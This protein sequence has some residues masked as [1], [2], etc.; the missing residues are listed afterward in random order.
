MQRPTNKEE[1][2]KF[3]QDA[4]NQI[5][6]FIYSKDEKK[7][8]Q[9]FKTKERDKNIRDVIY[10][11][12]GWHALL[13]DWYLVHVE[14]G[15]PI[16]PKQGHTWDRL[17]L[18]NQ[19]IWVEAQAYTLDHTLLIFDKSHQQVMDLIRGLSEKELYES[20]MFSWAGKAPLAHLV[21]AIMVHHYHWA[22]EYLN[23]L[24]TLPK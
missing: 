19:D 1:L 7:R 13:L 9:S 23:K 5:I 6:R 15:R 14:G 3:S 10:H 21:D 11:L 4:Y 12:Y 18:L 24:F 2:L 20:G 22:M 16:L 17:D 8:N